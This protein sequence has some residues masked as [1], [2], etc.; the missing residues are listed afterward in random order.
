MTGARAATSFTLIMQKRQKC[1]PYGT[2]G[3]SLDRG[4]VR[5]AVAADYEAWT[6]GK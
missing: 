3:C 5:D 2:D 1:R 4:G 6:P